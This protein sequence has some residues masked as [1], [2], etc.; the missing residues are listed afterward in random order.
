MT[1]KLV[2]I[3][4]SITEQDNPQD[5]QTLQNDIQSIMFGLPK[6]CTPIFG[7]S[8][9][10]VFL[11]KTDH[12]YLYLLDDGHFGE[13]N[14]QQT[15][16]LTI[17]DEAA[18]FKYGANHLCSLIQKALEKILKTLRASSEYVSTR[19]K[20]EARMVSKKGFIGMRDEE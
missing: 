9:L 13:L 8:Q 7:S 17:T 14:I 18:V 2:T 10:G 15:S 5:L 6:V 4:A 3:M 16:L 1:N 11:E 12:C 20:E 19:L